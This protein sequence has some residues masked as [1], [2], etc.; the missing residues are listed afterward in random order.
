MLRIDALT[1]I[2]IQELSEG[3][4]FIATD[5]EPFLAGAVEDTKVFIALG[6]KRFYFSER[7]EWNRRGFVI[8]G[9]RYE[10]DLESAE[11][12]SGWEEA[13]LGALVRFADGFGIGGRD[14]HYQHLMALE[15][16]PSEEEPRH[17]VIFRKWQIVVGEGTA[18]EILYSQDPAVG[19]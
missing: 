15:G 2:R 8:D 1:P 9:V 16:V 11:F 10:V 19:A 13:P 5:G 18:K 3:Q 7:K 12:T 14:N 6:A 17:V 4:L